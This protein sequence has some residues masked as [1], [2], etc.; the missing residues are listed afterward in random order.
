MRLDFDRLLAD[1]ARR[2]P[3]GAAVL[4][5][6]LRLTYPELQALAERIGRD[7]AAAGARAG[8]RVAALFPNCHLY[9]AAYFAAL[10][11]GLILVPINIRLLPR[12]VEAVLGHSG[13][14]VVIG[15]TGLVGCLALRAL[16][17][18]DGY[19][20][21][22]FDAGP[23][24]GCGAPA[25]AD[26]PAGPDEPAAGAENVT[27]LYYTSGTTGRP[28]GVMLTRGNQAAHAAMTIRELRLGET[29]VW[30]HAAPMFHLA[31]AWAVWS[32]TAACGTHVLMPRYEPDA[33][34]ALM[35]SSSTTLTNLVPAMIPG[36]LASARAR[37]DGRPKLR[38]LLSGGAP[39]PPRLA[40][41]IEAALGCEYAQTYGLTETTPFLTFSLLSEAQRRDLPAEEQRRLRARTGR[42]A[43]GVQL[44][45]VWPSDAADLEDVPKDDA[46]VGEVVARGE[47][48]S[49][50]YWRDPDATAAAFRGGWFHTGDLGTVD[51]HGSL[52]LV[53]RIKDVIV[54]GGEKVYSIEVES[55]LL[56]HPGVREAAV[57][58]VP[59]DTWGEAVRASVVGALPGVLGAPSPEDLVAFCRERLAAFKCPRVVERLEEMPRTGSGKIDKKALREPHW[60]DR[61][62]RIN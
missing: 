22:R 29:D 56:Q 55:V 32:L 40:D 13:T 43:L 3:T 46:T 53:D 9:L 6:S 19:D 24:S 36:L 4:C 11:R 41:E 8:D 52:N 50:G 28:K 31:D 23:P 10:A 2:R 5:G 59:D 38:L 44:R 16:D 26:E 49:P 12:E 21:G 35:R 54:T 33:A 18:R 42:P 37:P 15:Q 27:H 62:A 45:V 48:V 61:P 20:V 7:L 51:R 58:A 39:M 1:A 30:L 14:R 17:Q 57:Y 34:L 25:A 47:T 60:R